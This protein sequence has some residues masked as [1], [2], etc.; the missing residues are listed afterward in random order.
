MIGIKTLDTIKSFPKSI[1]ILVIGEGISALAMGIFN[2]L[3]ILYY[4][5]IG[6]SP[7]AIGVIF[8][9]GSLFTL[10]GF[11]IGPFIKIF[12]RKN[13]L[14]IGVVILSIGIGIHI[15]FKGFIILLIGQIIISIGTSLIQVTELQ[16]LYS[17][18]V[19]YKECCAYSY[20]YSSALIA[21]ALGILIAGNMERIP[22]FIGQ[23]YRRLFF[24]AFIMLFMTAVARYFLLPKDI[25][26][27]AENGEVKRLLTLSLN[28]IKTDVNIRR[29]AALLFFA[30]LGF[31]GVGPY[32]NLI[33]KIAFALD[34]QI[35]SYIS[36][37][38][39]ILS[40]IGIVM[41]PTI[42]E[43]FGVEKFNLIIFSVTITCCGLL[44]LINTTGLFIGVLIIRCTFAFMIASSLESL[45][46]SNIDLE[47]RDIF[48]SVKMLVNG[49]AV[50]LGNF[51]GGFILNHFGYKGNYLY[52][53]I[54]LTIA[55]VFFYTRVRSCMLNKAVVK[56]EC[57][58]HFKKKSVVYKKE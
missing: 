6:L 56:T 15:V 8:S 2:F 51:L 36:F 57:K 44:S 24:A 34:N 33:L 31:A 42:I 58:C 5:F 35:I 18:T 26:I 54:I 20:K 4:N 32:N 16:L 37:T 19:G 14:C 23:G 28:S 1:H 46:M 9:L 49:I 29:F 45:M 52:G 7:E 40:M 39:T 3:Q 38:L 43:K 13:L 27:E 25:T 50:A 12:G 11:F 30:T 55:V 48:A 41:M 53:A 10:T 22:Y 47:R 21:N 17:Y